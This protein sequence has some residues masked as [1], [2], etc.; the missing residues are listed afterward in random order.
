MN[1]DS[2][3]RAVALLERFWMTVGVLLVVVGQIGLSMLWTSYRGGIDQVDTAMLL[4]S[5]MAAPPF[6]YMGLIMLGSL[7]QEF[8]EFFE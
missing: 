1:T 4:I 2:D 5:T 3:Q 8:P 7:E 6:G